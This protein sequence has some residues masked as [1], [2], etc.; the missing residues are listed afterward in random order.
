MWC[1]S[2][3]TLSGDNL[4]HH[5]IHDFS[6]EFSLFR[7]IVSIVNILPSGGRIG[8]TTDPKK[9]L[10]VKFLFNYQTDFRY[11]GG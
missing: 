5:Q 10:Y 3:R 8:G 9:Q 6:M 7:D 11:E 1:R 2:P 4:Q